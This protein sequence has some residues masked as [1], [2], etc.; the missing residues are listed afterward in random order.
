MDKVVE[1]RKMGERQRG[2][3]QRYLAVGHSLTL[4]CKKMSSKKLNTTEHT[5]HAE[6]ICCLG[7]VILL[8]CRYFDL[9]LSM[10]QPWL[11]T[12]AYLISFITSI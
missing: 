9:S 2:R 6:V 8:R 5:E 1:E 3:Y 11:Y 4:A 10:S 7:V 12:W